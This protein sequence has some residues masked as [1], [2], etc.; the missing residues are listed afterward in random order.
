[1][2]GGA[3]R[4]VA[5]AAA[6]HQHGRALVLLGGAGGGGVAGAAHGLPGALRELVGAVEAV[7]RVGRVVAARLALA[8]GGELATARG[9]GG[10]SVLRPQPLDLTTEA[11]VGPEA[12]RG[13]RLVGE[14]AVGPQQAVV[15]VVAHLRAQ[16]R[17]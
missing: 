2:S 7:A 8:D 6:G 17:L 9:G 12:R 14:A 15:L 10:G 4:P 13:L 5:G 1:M 11:A 16:R 3:D